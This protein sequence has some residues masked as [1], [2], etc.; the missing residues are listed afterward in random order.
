MSI[1]YAYSGTIMSGLKSEARINGRHEL[2]MSI[3]F[4]GNE[5]V[6][7]GK[8]KKVVD[9]YKNLYQLDYDNKHKDFLSGCYLLANIE[10][11][12]R[13]N[14]KWHIGAFTSWGKSD[15]NYKKQYDYKL[16]IRKGYGS[17][18]SS[19][20]AVAPSLRYTWKESSYARCYSRI[21]M[22]LMYHSQ[23]FH[24]KET[25]LDSEYKPN[26]S[27][28]DDCGEAKWCTAYQITLIGGSAG[29]ETF[30]FFG[31]LGCGCLGVLRV[32]LNLCF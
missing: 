2:N 19:F 26:E 9:H 15:D 30:R 14:N 25:T 21:A 16:P 31:E 23:S 11:H 18:S 8:K 13:L 24:Y 28:K 32:G 4:D 22:G 27:V 5:T 29:N 10:Y 12:Y 20:F 3:G 17:E 7:A 1:P 6:D